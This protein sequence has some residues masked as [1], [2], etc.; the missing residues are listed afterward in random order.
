MSSQLLLKDT[1]LLVF[2]LS[3]AYTHVLPWMP[4]AV[5]PKVRTGTSG[6]HEVDSWGVVFSTLT[7]PSSGCLPLS[8]RCEALAGK[9][10]ARRVVF[11]VASRGT[12]ADARLVPESGVVY[13]AYNYSTYISLRY[14]VIN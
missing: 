14:R 13:G 12:P 10:N 2:V 7:E 3:T 1:F 5:H 6:L 11:D 8:S 4:R 9:I